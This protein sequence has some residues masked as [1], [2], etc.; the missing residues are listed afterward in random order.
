MLKRICTIFTIVILFGSLL[1]I[2]C[3]EEK[4]LITA[5]DGHFIKVHYTGTLKDGTIFDT[6]RG[7]Q[8]LEFTLGTGQLIPGFENAVRGMSVGQSKTVTIPPEEAYGPFRDDLI[9]TIDKG[10]LPDDSDPEIGQ[11]VQ[12][13]LGGNISTQAIIT[14]I[15]ETTITVDANHHLAGKDLT[16]EIEVV[17]IR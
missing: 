17:E 12:I 10:E 8:P 1:N 13:K 9:F 3:T 4:E 6:S 2:G 15:S 7:R 11:Q 16:F 14:D 5:E